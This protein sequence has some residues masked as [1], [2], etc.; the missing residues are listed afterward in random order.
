MYRLLETQRITD[1]QIIIVKQ[2]EEHP[3]GKKKRGFL[4]NASPSQ[5]SERYP[6]SSSWP[7]KIYRI[8]I[9]SN[10]LTP[11]TNLWKCFLPYS[12]GS[13]IFAI[14]MTCQIFASKF[15]WSTDLSEHLSITVSLYTLNNCKVKL[16]H[17]SQHCYLEEPAGSSRLVYKPQYAFLQLLSVLHPFLVS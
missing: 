8:N 3:C 12:E 9:T 5:K 6:G 1:F 11:F 2:S 7:S 16:P 4:L 14:N 13:I 15:C 17:F 10:Y